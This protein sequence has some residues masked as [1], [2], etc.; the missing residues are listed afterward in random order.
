MTFPHFSISLLRGL[1]SSERERE[2]T[3]TFWFAPLSAFYVLLDPRRNRINKRLCLRTQ[4]RDV[5]DKKER[6]AIKAQCTISWRV[7]IHSHG[8]R[9]TFS[10]IVIVITKKKTTTK[11]KTKNTEDD[12]EYYHSQRQRR[13]RLA[14]RF[15]GGEGEREGEEEGAK[16]FQRLLPTKK[17]PRRIRA[18][19]RRSERRRKRGDA[20]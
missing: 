7:L 3:A 11:K 4:R 8:E 9:S 18:K 19:T 5:K 17:Q 2:T 6:D 14:E 1:D 12:G 13:R 16:Q 20:A 15:R 10:Q